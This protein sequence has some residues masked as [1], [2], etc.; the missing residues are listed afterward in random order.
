M[1]FALKSAKISDWS[2]A[3]DPVDIDQIRQDATY[4]TGMIDIGDYLLVIQLFGSS[5]VASWWCA[6][7]NGK[8][9]LKDDDDFHHEWLTSPSKEWR[10][11]EEERVL[12][13]R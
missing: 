8:E 12:A 2:R 9:F 4:T 10:G 13:R 3:C 7:K 1:N 6:A 11:T 5:L